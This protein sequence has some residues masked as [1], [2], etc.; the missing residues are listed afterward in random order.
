MSLTGT[1]SPYFHF[2]AG[3]ILPSPMVTGTDFNAAQVNMVLNANTGGRKRKRSLAKSSRKKR[4]RRGGGGRRRRTK[5]R[6]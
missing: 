4:T 3:G 1:G 2:P 6:K 5:Y